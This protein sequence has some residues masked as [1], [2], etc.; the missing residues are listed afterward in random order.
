MEEKE[1]VN[2]LK[3]R[4]LESCEEQIRHKGLSFTVDELASELGISKKTLYAEIGSKEQ[5]LEEIIYRMKADIHEQQE[6][7]CR[8]QGLNHVEKMKG[9]LTISPSQ[10]LVASPMVMAQLKK[11]FPRLYQLVWDIYHRDW[12]GFDRLYEEGVRE[13]VFAPFDLVFFKELYIVAV[14]GL[15][16]EKAL[17]DRSYQELLNQTVE[18]LF[19]GA[20]KGV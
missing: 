8:E 13:K 9:L 5:M 18:V 17:S 10:S 3:N 6:K 2:L 16:L 15:P 19:H 4:I 11:G 12:E 14:T 20:V 7:L 1:V